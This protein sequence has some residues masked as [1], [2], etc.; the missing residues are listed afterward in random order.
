MFAAP[1][2]VV[3]RTA[4]DLT[5]RCKVQGMTLQSK[6][7]PTPPPPTTHTL[8]QTPSPFYLSAVWSLQHGQ[9]CVE[10]PTEVGGQL[11]VDVLQGVT[12]WQR[13]V[14]HV[15]VR[16]FFGGQGGGRTRGWGGAGGGVREHMSGMCAR[17]VFVPWV[18]VWGVINRQQL[19][20][21]GRRDACNGVCAPPPP[22]A[23]QTSPVQTTH[24][25]T[26]AHLKSTLSSCRYASGSRCCVAASRHLLSSAT[27]VGTS[28]ASPS[29]RVRP[30]NTRRYSFWIRGT[31]CKGGE[32]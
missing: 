16:C 8:T 27:S 30:R 26:S 22:C 28:I 10:C 15:P 24:T 20:S 11:R 2:C 32:G 9:Q 31:S 19:L 5:G 21:Q 3:C 4:D 29:G 25:R 13:A 14:V 1:Q 18:C 12:T 6:S 7:L 23:R 17:V